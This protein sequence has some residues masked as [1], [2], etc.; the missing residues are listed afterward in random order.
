MG[1][2]LKKSALSLR[3]LVSFMRLL[4]GSTTTLQPSIPERRLRPIQM[5]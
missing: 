5:R 2:G 4:V 1:A 3:D